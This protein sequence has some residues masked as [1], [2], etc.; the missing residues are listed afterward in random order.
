MRGESVRETH[1]GY[2]CVTLREQFGYDVLAGSSSGTKEEEMHALGQWEVL[3]AR[4]CEEK[5]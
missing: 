2:R 5:K 1:Q 3:G 4:N